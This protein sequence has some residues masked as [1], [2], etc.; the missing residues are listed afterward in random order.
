MKTPTIGKTL[1]SLG[2]KP[3][4]TSMRE[5]QKSAS[6]SLFTFIDEVVD[7]KLSMYELAYAKNPIVPITE[8]EEQFYSS[9]ES[10]TVVELEEYVKETINNIP[11]SEV[12][13]N[14]ENIYKQERKNNKRK[15]VLVDFCNKL[16]KLQLDVAEELKQTVVL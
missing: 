8:E 13:V 3:L 6:Q 5:F 10:K 14:I 16:P 1:Q 9:F 4:S 7:K 12:K 2:G 11:N 15:H